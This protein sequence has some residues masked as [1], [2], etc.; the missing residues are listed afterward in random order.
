GPRRSSEDPSRAGPGRLRR[1][2]DPL[3]LGLPDV[4]RAG[5]FARRLPGRLRDP[6]RQHGGP[7][8]RHREIPDRQSADAPFHRGTFRHGPGEGGAPPAAPGRDRPRRARRGGPTRRGRPVPREGE[9]L[10]LDR[11]ADARLVQDPLRHQHRARARRGRGDAR[12]PRPRRRRRRPRA[13]RPRAVRGADRRHPRRADPGARRPMSLKAKRWILHVLRIAVTAAA[14]VVVVRMIRW[15]DHWVVQAVDGRE[16]T[17][18]A[19]QIRG[20]RQDPTRSYPHVVTWADGRETTHP[21]ADRRQGFLSLFDRTNKAFFFGMMCALM[22]PLLCT[23]WRWWLLLRGHGF[24][25]RYGQAFFIS[26]AGAFFNNFLPGSVGGDLTKAI[27][28][29]SGE[30]RKAAVAGTVILDRII[31]LAVMIIMGA[32]CLTPYVERF[33]NKNLAYLIYGLLGA[34]VLGYLLYFSPPAR[35]LVERLPFKK[36]TSELDGVFRAVWEKKALVGAAGGL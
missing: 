23:S 5:R 31:G 24:Q 15:Q 26:Y 32:T 4:R 18:D 12:A 17:Y 27:L 7:R 3:A 20:V 8:G 11:D 33:A 28:A 30:E 25:A 29:S 16:W 9:A 14:V 36:V 34:M 35:W 10:D 22:I 19:A 13:S 2:A 6:V 1:H 21:H